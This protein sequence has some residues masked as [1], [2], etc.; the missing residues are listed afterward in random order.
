MLPPAFGAEITDDD[1]ERTGERREGAYY[2]TWGLFDQLVNGIAAATLPLLL[3]LGSSRSDPHGPLGVRMV[4]LVCGLF[5]VIAFLI[6]Q[7]YPFR[8]RVNSAR[9]RQIARGIPE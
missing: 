7:R 4:G 3:L 9:Q 5:M 8:E 6:F 2:A 1:A